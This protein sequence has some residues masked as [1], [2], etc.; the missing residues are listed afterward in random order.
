M[1]KQP[2][3]QE[4]KNLEDLIESLSDSYESTPLF[5]PSTI[6][7]TDT[8][9]QIKEAF[10]IIGKYRN[11]A[12][13]DFDFTEIQADCLDLRSIQAGLSYSLSVY[14]SYASTSK[15]QLEIARAKAKIAAKKKKAE[16]DSEGKAIKLTAEDTKDIALILTEELAVDLAE[17]TQ[18]AEFCKSIYFAVKD[19]LY[20]LEAALQRL[21]NRGE[22]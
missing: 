17:K 21:H 4:S 20:T 14:I 10:D 3:K 19:Q 16:L 1:I 7:P 9:T 18:C 2:G 6:L 8:Y 15:D 12:F 11:G 22:Q 13:T 5:D